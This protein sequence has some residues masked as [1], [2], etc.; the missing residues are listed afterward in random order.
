MTDGESEN[1]VLLRSKRNIMIDGE[2]KP[3]NRK[4]NV[5]FIDADG[6]QT[7]TPLPLMGE[8]QRLFKPEKVIKRELKK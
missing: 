4:E 7:S 6:K 5:M 8:I 1:D 2:P 3:K